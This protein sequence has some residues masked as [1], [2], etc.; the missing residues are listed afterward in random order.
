MS[1]KLIVVKMVGALALQFTKAPH[2]VEHTFEGEGVTVNLN[3]S[4]VAT[5]DSVCEKR[6]KKCHLIINI[7]VPVNGGINAVFGAPFKS[8][9]QAKF[10]GKAIRAAIKDYEES[11]AAE[12][13]PSV[14]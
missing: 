4:Q 9:E 2:Y 6:D 1:I 14:L 7:G 10:A 13:K 8:D 5:I 3:S 11:T 12:V